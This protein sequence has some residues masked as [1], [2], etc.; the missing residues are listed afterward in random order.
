[1][2]SRLSSFFKN[3]Q[4]QEAKHSF[5]IMRIK[6]F[7]ANLDIR[8][9]KKNGRLYDDK[10]I[11]VIKQ[12]FQTEAHGGYNL[13]YLNKKANELDEAKG[14]EFKYPIVVV[15]GD[16]KK[17]YCAIYQKAGEGGFGSFKILQ[18]LDT[19]EFVR[20]KGNKVFTDEAE[21]EFQTKTAKNY[22]L[23]EHAFFQASIEMDPKNKTPLLPKFYKDKERKIA[24][25]EKLQMLMK[26]EPGITPSMFA[27]DPYYLFREKIHPVRLLDIAI[28][29]GVKQA[30][31]HAA[32]YIYRDAN[33]ANLLVDFSGDS[34]AW[35]DFGTAKKPES[36]SKSV[37]E[38]MIVGSTD[39]LAPEIFNAAL[40][41]LKE[42]T[43]ERYDYNEKTDIY[44]LATTL[45]LLL[46][47]EFSQFRSPGKWEVC[48]FPTRLSSHA[49][50]EAI[51]KQMSEENPNERITDEE[52]LTKLFEYRN[53]IATEHPLKIAFVDIVEFHK[54]SNERSL[55]FPYLE[56]LNNYDEIIFTGDLDKWETL[57]G[58]NFR[59]Q[60]YFQ[61]FNRKFIVK[62]DCLKTVDPEVIKAYCQ[63]LEERDGIPIQATQ[64]SYSAS[65]GIVETKMNSRL[66]EISCRV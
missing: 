9:L 46:G 16:K 44:A 23:A 32:G 2:L 58:V 1:M 30:N 33:F 52:M 61:T 10:A 26:I 3:K 39:I 36:G 55:L 6:Y 14:M 49:E 62:R 51:L 48:Q 31:V 43:P 20:L 38:D 40:Q 65:T 45:K 57:D 4:E 50:L 28:A 60:N 18:N 63:Y 13:C 11:G 54:I 7:P 12:I 5:P 15:Q 47:F 66:G 17:E 29:A 59:L 19:G 21:A 35:I 25:P 37:I 42:K 53:K 41:F 22:I 56:K 8:L 27:Q 24:K 34:A 64:L